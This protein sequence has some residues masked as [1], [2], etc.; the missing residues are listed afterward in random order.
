MS[1]TDAQGDDDD[2]L[3]NVYPVVRGKYDLYRFLEEEGL[4]GHASCTVENT[5]ICWGGTAANQE[6]YR[7]SDRILM[8]PTSVMHGR[9]HP[10]W[11][12]ARCDQGEIPPPTSGASMVYVQGQLIIFGGYAVTL[13]EDTVSFSNSVFVNDVYS[14]NPCTMLWTRIR[15]DE[16]AKR[17]TAR[18][19]MVSWSHR[20]CAFFFSGF[21]ASYSQCA[22]EIRDGDV[23]SDS[24]NEGDFMWNNQLVRFN[25]NRGEWDFVETS[26]QIPSP[27]AA[28]AGCSTNEG[29]TVFVFG[30]RSGPR[31]LFDLYTLDMGSL[32]WSSISM[33][34]CMDGLSPATPLGRS[35]ATMQ[36]SEDGSRLYV[37][38]GLL[39]ADANAPE[40]SSAELFEADLPRRLWRLLTKNMSRRYWHSGAFNN[41]TLRAVGGIG[42]HDRRIYFETVVAPSVDCIRLQPYS[43]RYI[44]F[45]KL[46]AAVTRQ[47][48]VP[49]SLQNSLSLRS[50]MGDRPCPAATSWLAAQSIA[51]I[52]RHGSLYI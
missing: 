27:R 32:I 10:L 24:G 52:I 26:G 36:A 41:G 30:G 28:A 22:D 6:E 7:R 42:H 40:T 16:G 45:S 19:K 20:D 13:N 51:D 2:V 1:D 25:P 21:G 3:V 11:L 8:L 12:Q 43:L 14:L 50:L 4:S 29:G 38:G 15:Y 34:M 23:I 35:F 37:W 48:A 17:P 18:D 31:R 5:I 39:H 46:N 47:F 33:T 49:R 44:A 9:F